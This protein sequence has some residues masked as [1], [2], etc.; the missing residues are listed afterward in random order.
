MLLCYQIMNFHWHM[1][2][3]LLYFQAHGL[4]NEEGVFIEQLETNPVKYL[5]DVQ[6]GEL[7]SD[8]VKV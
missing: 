3:I 6:E 2:V 1:L 8:V 7:S 4:I 5:P